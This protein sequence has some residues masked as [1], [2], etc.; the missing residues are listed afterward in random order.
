MHNT[1]CPKELKAARKKAGLTQA[2]LGKLAGF[3]RIAVSRIESRTRPTKAVS[4]TRFV[5]ALNGLGFDIKPVQSYR[6]QVPD[7]L[8]LLYSIPGI[9]TAYPRCGAMTRKGTLCR[10]KPMPGKKRCSYH[11]GM[12]TGPKTQAGKGRI[13]Q[14]QIARW[15][16]YREQA[17]ADQN[18][19]FSDTKRARDLGITKSNVLSGPNNHMTRKKVLISRINRV[20]D[21]DASQML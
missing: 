17:S 13:R 21:L 7:M 15:C 16:K 12:S 10:C 14:A 9:P 18:V 2:E 3:T 6:R 1:Y 19:T 4:M 5:D 20:V 11:G 8:N